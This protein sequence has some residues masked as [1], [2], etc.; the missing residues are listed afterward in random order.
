MNIKLTDT[1][2]LNK[3]CAEN[4]EKT[5]VRT[6]PVNPPVPLILEDLLDGVARLYAAVGLLNHQNK[7]ILS[8][9]QGFEAAKAKEC[10]AAPVEPELPPSKL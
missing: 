10:A 2:N 1:P 5:K 4:Y 3:W 7:I 9:L 8:Y 6:Y